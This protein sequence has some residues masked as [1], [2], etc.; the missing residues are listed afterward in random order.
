M[1]IINVIICL[2]NMC[3]KHCV[4]YNLHSA[5]IYVINI[6]SIAVKTEKS[7][8]SYII[9]RTPLEKSFRA[10]MGY[11]GIIIIM[12]LKHHVFEIITIRY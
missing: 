2:L 11:P 8:V 10:F 7:N 12:S 9:N 4:W 3:S 1:H 6:Y 5:N